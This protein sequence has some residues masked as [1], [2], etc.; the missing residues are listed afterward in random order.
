MAPHQPSGS[1][2]RR[3]HVLMLGG[4]F[5]FVRDW[6]ACASEVA[7]VTL[8]RTR[9]SPGEAA[10]SE[11]SVFVRQIRLRPTRIFRRLNGALDRLFLARA[12]SALRTEDPVT[13]LHT[14]FYSASPAAV[15][16]ARSTGLPLV[17]TEHSSAIL[18]NTVS[19]TGLRML[20]SVC[21]QAHTVTAVSEPLAEAI[22]R[23]GMA[24]RVQVLPNPVDLNAFAHSFLDSEPKGLRAVQFVSV[25]WL[26]PIKD[27]A[28]LLEAF[29]IC[30]LTLP[31]SKLVIIGE[32][33][34]RH[35]LEGLAMDLGIGPA[36][37]F[38]G[39]LARND[40]ARRLR[41]STV[42]VHTSRSETFGVALVEAWASGLPVVTVDCGGVS[43]IAQS[44]GGVMV[45]GRDPVHLASAMLHEAQ[46]R[47][48]QAEIQ[49]RCR[50]TFSTSRVSAKLREIYESASRDR[51]SQCT[52]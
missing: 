49:Q 31:D 24:R 19:K 20:R 51:D 26:I 3:I 10:S 9:E 4:D 38:A 36:V 18:N 41:E 46:P 11:H 23:H 40:V 35:R 48:D 29:R 32:G 39:A 16:V 50:D 2:N 5:T 28:L 44:I 17:H 22:R 27:H 25:G 15:A 52:E 47:T 6:A 37:E 45:A 30:T 42:Y 43:R 14:H 21:E 12:V 1:A 33:H 7:D 34:E 8:V 13:C